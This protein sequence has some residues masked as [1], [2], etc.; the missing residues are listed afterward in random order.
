VVTNYTGPAFTGAPAGSWANAGSILGIFGA[1]NSAIGTYF[2]LASQKTAG[3]SQESSYR[4]QQAMAGIN[5]QIADENARDIQA[6]GQREV[7]RYTMQAGAEKA[8]NKVAQAASGVRLGKGSAAEVIASGDILAK[9]DRYNIEANIARSVAQA[10]MQATDIRN[11]GLMA[12]A[13]AENVRASHRSINPY[14]GV[15]TS[16]LSNA[17][18]LAQEWRYAQRRKEIT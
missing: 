9:I 14:T 10:R 17:G 8:R 11:Q 13:S 6:A 15:T 18:T 5:A 7:G 4:H 2:D 12:G 3:K 1:L 16:L